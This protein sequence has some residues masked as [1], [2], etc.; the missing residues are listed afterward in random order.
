MSNAPQSEPLEDSQDNYVENR[1]PTELAMCVILAAAYLGLA[2]FL[3]A[4]LVE[5]GNWKMLINVEG[6]FI[7]I[8][9]V[10]IL[11]GL[12]PY[13]SPSSLQLSRHGIKYR[14]TYW[15]QRKTVNWDQVVQLY[16]SPELVIVI[17]KLNKDGKRVWPML[18]SS[19]YLA[20]REKIPNSFVKFCPIEPIIM[21]GPHLISRIVIVVLFCITLIWVLEL[22][23]NPTS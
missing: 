3:W 9:L 10:S 1:D 5:T 6:F 7:T 15:P 13:L 12:R 14:G 2:K 4:K 19:L 20:E 16:I 23:V 8:A 18:I 22:L 21:S 17:Y 11:V